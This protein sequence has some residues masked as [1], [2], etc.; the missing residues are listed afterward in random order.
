[1][2]KGNITRTLKSKRFGDGRVA[3]CQANLI[4]TFQAYS[5][6]Q[7]SR[8]QSY[9]IYHLPINTITTVIIFAQRNPFIF[10][11]HASDTSMH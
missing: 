9:F 11:E 7:K 1:M 6:H 8:L 3:K 4:L 2:E 10:Q 5:A